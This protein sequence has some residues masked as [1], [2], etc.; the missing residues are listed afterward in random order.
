[1]FMFRSEKHASENPY[2]AADAYGNIQYMHCI[3][4]HNGV[5]FGFKER[6]TFI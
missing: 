2:D 3:I 6:C 5:V 1:M 4:L